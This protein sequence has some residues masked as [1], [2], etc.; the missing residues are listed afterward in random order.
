MTLR[1]KLEI[2]PF[3][4]ESDSYEIF[5]MDISNTGTVRNMGF[6]HEI[7]SYK[8]KIMKPVPPILIKDGVTHEVYHEGIIPEHD[9]RD[10]PWVLVSKCLEG[11]D[12]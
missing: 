6:G 7:C 1:V 11:F 10:G 12:G 9:R 3:G 2:V 5:Y 4:V 8:F